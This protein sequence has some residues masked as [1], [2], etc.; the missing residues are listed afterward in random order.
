MITIKYR[1]E[2]IYP[3]TPE[4]T[5][6]IIMRNVKTNKVHSCYITYS[7]PL[8]IHFYNTCKIWTI[9]IKQIFFYLKL[10]KEKNWKLL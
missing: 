5:W 7:H 10:W 2:K 8:D 6:L 3:P 4:K 1:V 9:V